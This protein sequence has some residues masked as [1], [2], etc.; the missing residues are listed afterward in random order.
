MTIE[1]YVQKNSAEE[2]IVPLEISR[3]RRIHGYVMVDQYRAKKI[4]LRDGYREHGS[5][6]E[7]VGKGLSI[8]LKDFSSFVDR[9]L[10]IQAAL[11]ARGEVQ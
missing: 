2:L 4:D 5:V 6:T 8:P 9:I 7:E 3:R 11:R 1:E 10:E